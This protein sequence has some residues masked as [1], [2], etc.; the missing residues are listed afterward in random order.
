MNKK[1]LPKSYFLIFLIGGYLLYSV[2]LVSAIQQCESAVSIHI[3]PL[4]PEPPYPTPLGLHR[5]P[6]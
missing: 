5:A 2:V 3:Y 1:C 4:P 6:D